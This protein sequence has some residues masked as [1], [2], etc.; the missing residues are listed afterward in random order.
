MTMGRLGDQGVT[1]GVCHDGAQEGC[2][3]MVTSLHD[4]HDQQKKPVAWLIEYSGGP[5]CG[6]PFEC[7]ADSR[8]ELEQELARNTTHW[9]PD[10]DDTLALADDVFP[11][12]LKSAR[13]RLLERIRKGLHH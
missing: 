6:D 4:Q 9:L 5:S 2:Y 8:L 7:T 12:R 11:R 1:F 13:E 10:D 3:V